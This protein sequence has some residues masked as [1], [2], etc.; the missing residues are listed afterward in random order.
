MEHL[1]ALRRDLH[2]HPELGF[3]EQRTSDI[4]ANF[5]QQLGI[6]V[7]RGIGKTGVVGILKKGSSERM[8]GL[9]ADMDALPMQDRSGTD[10]QSR[11]EQVSHACGHDGHTVMLLGA[12]EKLA[13]DV[14]FDGSVCFIFQ[15]AE[16]GLAGAKAMIDDGLFSRFPC[17]AVYAIHNWPE[18]PLGQVQTRPGAIMAAADRFDIRVLGGGGHAAQ[19][20]LTRDTLLATSELVVQL[21]T[22]VSRALDPCETALLTVTRMQGGFSHNMIPAEANITGTVRSFS[23]AAQATIEARLRQMAEHITAAHGLHAEVSYLRYYPATLNSAA[24]AQFCLQALT[25]AGITAEAAPQPALTSEDFAFMLQARPGAYLW[26]GSAPCKPLHHAAYDFNDALIPHG[27]NVFVT[28]IR[29]ALAEKFP[30]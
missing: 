19:P 22:L 8:I 12:A 6:E 30:C 15:P 3:Q 11:A 23:P 10:W 26:L 5:L 21:N 13:R 17:E 16:E 28:L 2:A 4:V 24:E 27:V 18:L 9:R 1:V 14:S 20:H 29:Q 25:Q 7:H